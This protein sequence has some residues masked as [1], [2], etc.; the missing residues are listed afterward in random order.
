MKQSSLRKTWVTPSIRSHNSG[1]NKFGAARHHLVT[2]AIEGTP[3]AE[4]IARFG[5]PLFVFSEKRLRENA[6]RLVRAFATRWPR[7]INAWSYKTNYLGAVCNTLHQE[8]YWAEVVSAFEYEKARAL[9]VP[10]NRII[11]NGPYKPR[12]ALERAAAEG[13]RIHLDSLDELYSLEEVARRLGKALPVGI[14]LNFDTGLTDP[15]SRFGFNL[16]SGQALDAARR[17]A[18]SSHLKLTGLHSH[19]GTFITDPRAYAAAVRILTAFMDTVEIQ[20]GA[21]IEYLDIGGGFASR[22]ALQG[23]YLPPEQIVPSPE[24]YAEAVCD[25]LMAGTR[26]R[27]AR[28]LPRPALILETGRAVVDDAGSLIAS[29]AAN[30]RLPDGRRGVV[31][32]AGVNL[33]FTAFWYN[34]EVRPARRLEGIPEETVLYGPLCM[35]IDVLRHSVQMPP[36][37]VGDLLVFHPAGAYNNSQWLQ[38]I[39]YRPNVVMLMEGG[40]AEVVRVREDL[41]VVTAQ[42]RLPACLAQP[43]IEDGDGAD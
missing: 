19:I 25:A 12:A 22:N 14:R 3:V 34:H 5:S 32:D 40:G 42:E 4:L 31:L 33:L 6:R 17:V 20:T 41:S 21:L 11:F 10:G 30:K 38:F 7:V 24:Q 1:L 8:G 43:Y 23:V 36:L 2:E 16:E 13:A 28:G 35:N 39:E 27:E 37:V 26:E 18:S 29:V 9:G 15:W